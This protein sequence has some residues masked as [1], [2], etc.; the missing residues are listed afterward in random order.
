M[1]KKLGQQPTLGSR[2]LA[3]QDSIKVR[4][5]L[6]ANAIE[7]L[8]DIMVTLATELHDETAKGAIQDAL[9][10]FRN[11]WHPHFDNFRKDE[12]HGS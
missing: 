6:L 2:P 12:H 3:A 5:V 8:F 7:D 1:D 10:V 4:S 11:N 9:E